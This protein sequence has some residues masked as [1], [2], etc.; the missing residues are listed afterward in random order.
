MTRMRMPWR[1]R[2]NRFL[3]LKAIG[4]VLF[5]IPGFVYGFWWATGQLGGRAVN[6]VI[7][8][9]GLWSVRFLL[10]ALAITPLARVLDWPRL[11]T[12]RRMAGV[13][14]ACYAAIHLLLYVVE[15]KY[16]LVVVGSEIIQR[17]YLT[18]GFIALTGLLALAATSTDGAIR[19]MGRGWKRLHLLAYPIGVLALWHY[20]LQSKANVAEAVFAAGL[21]TWLMLWRVLP[22]G[23]RRPVA[24]YPALAVVAG[25]LT[26][27]IEFGWYGLATN[28][29]PWR[30]LSANESIAFGLRPAHWVFLVTL[31]VAAVIA[32]RRV[33][34]SKRDVAVSA[35]RSSYPI[36]A[37]IAR[38]S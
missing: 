13:T 27:G 10:V 5:L 31:G 37:R 4:L 2:H 21:F 25:V 12:L 18:I 28:I 17:F 38:G 7:H 16:D 8:A 29:D 30:V 3:P 6:E 14:A 24:V 36:R 9:T 26:A 1:D 35:G 15:Q 33:V 23:W 32:L 20:A 34:P 11:L 19:R 22:E